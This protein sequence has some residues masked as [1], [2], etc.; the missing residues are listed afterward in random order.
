M[1]SNFNSQSLLLPNIVFFIFIHTTR[2]YVRVQLC[3]FASITDDVTAYLYAKITKLLSECL[4]TT[5]NVNS[6]NPLAY[7]LA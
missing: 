7:V 1:P 5:A 6:L 3:I 4:S 2:N